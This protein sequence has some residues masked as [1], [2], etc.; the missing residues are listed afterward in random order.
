[1]GRGLCAP[2]TSFDVGRNTSDHV[3]AFL[4]HCTVCPPPSQTHHPTHSG[5]LFCSCP[6]F[7]PC[8]FSP[9]S[10]FLVFKD[11]C[12]KKILCMAP[13]RHAGMT[14]YSRP[15][16]LASLGSSVSSCSQRVEFVKIQVAI[17]HADSCSSIAIMRMHISIFCGGQGTNSTHT[18]LFSNPHSSTA[19]N[20]L[21]IDA[22]AGI[23]CT[24]YK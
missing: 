3:L 16:A 13:S 21:S 7:C 24:R 18:H 14:E 17:V 23:S 22:F 1:V 10:K 9:K 4:Q 12:A 5:H 20:F 15:G 11:V 6:F 19:E 8:S 2:T